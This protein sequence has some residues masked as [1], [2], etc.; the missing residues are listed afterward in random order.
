MPSNIAQIL[1]FSTLALSVVLFILGFF[2]STF[3]LEW[4]IILI[5]LTAV[6]GAAGLAKEKVLATVV[7]AVAAV[8]FVGGL[9]RV[10]ILDHLLGSAV[11]SYVSIFFGLVTLGVSIFWLIVT[12]GK[13]KIAPE[14]GADEAVSTGDSAT[15]DE[16]AVAAPATT[17][18]YAYPAAIAP[19][20]DAA[21][22]TYAAATDT[23]ASAA[24]QVVDT[25]ASAAD[26]ATRVINTNPE[27][28]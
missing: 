25:A 20:A 28:R 8:A 15:A 11:I 1:A 3:N 18:G 23:A 16:A 6:A 13:V 22:G 27:Q 10:L 21:A 17:G 9:A 26:N 14:P 7:T 12:L 19:A 2:A 24:T 4:A 5:V